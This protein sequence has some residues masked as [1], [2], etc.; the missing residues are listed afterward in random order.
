MLMSEFPVVSV[1]IP[2]ALRRYTDGR[3]EVMASGETVGEILM[4]VAHS[5]PALGEHL[6][7]RDGELADGLK[8]YLGGNRLESANALETAVMQEE[9]VSLVAEGDVN[10]LPASGGNLHR[11]KNPT[12]QLVGGDISIGA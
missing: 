9:T 12:E 5:Y 8:I 1:H 10:A 7:C 2:P 4:A 11:A 6:Y 3:L